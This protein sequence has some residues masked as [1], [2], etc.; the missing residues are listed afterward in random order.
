[1][2]LNMSLHMDSVDGFLLGGSMEL[3]QASQLLKTIGGAENTK[4]NLSQ[5]TSNYLKIG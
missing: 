1:M 2:M 4:K 3:T 5:M